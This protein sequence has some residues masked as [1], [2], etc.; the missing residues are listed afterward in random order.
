MMQK[1]VSPDHTPTVIPRP[2]LLMSNGLSSWMPKR[3]IKPQ[4]LKI[5]LSFPPL[6]SFSLPP[7]IL[8]FLYVP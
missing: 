1:S 7:K 6:L 5:E 4:M 2:P 3:K 8:S